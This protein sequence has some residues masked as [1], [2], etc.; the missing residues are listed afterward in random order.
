MQE[1]LAQLTAQGLIIDPADVA[2]LSPIL[3]RQIN[4]LGQYEIALPESVAQGGLR[5][6]RNPTSE[7]EF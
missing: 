5:P 7:W 4:F 1:A 3:W 6:L 2:R